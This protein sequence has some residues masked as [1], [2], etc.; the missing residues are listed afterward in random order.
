VTITGNVL[1]N[2]AGRGILVDDPYGVGP[3]SGVVAH[4]NCLDGNVVAGLE[5][6]A[7]GH[8]GT[9]DAE[10]NWWG[11]ASG[12]SGA[13]PGTGDAVVGDVDFTPWALCSTACAT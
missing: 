4:D 2:G 7:G 12:P 11:D 9:L 1:R 8:T 6:S 13:G 5:V 3:N 10:R